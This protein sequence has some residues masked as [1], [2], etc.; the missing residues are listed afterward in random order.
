MQSV[1]QHIKY[2]NRFTDNDV[3]DLDVTSR[4][5]MDFLKIHPN[6]T[7]SILVFCSNSSWKVGNI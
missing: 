4:D 6:K 1:V 2:S 5:V 3:K 7:Q